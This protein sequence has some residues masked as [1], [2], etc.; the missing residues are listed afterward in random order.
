[1]GVKLQAGEFGIFPARLSK[2]RPYI[3]QAVLAWLWFHKN[4][5]T[6]SCFPSVATLQK[7]CGISS[8]HAVLNA[9][10][11]LEDAG[12]IVKDRRFDDKGNNKSN[13]YHIISNPEGGSAG[14]ALGGSALNAPG[15]VHEMHPNYKKVNN[16]NI[17]NK[18]EASILSE[19]ESAW[20]AYERKGN[21]QT[22]L[23]YWKK[24]SGEDRSS[25][26]KAIPLYIQSRPEKKFR[27]NFEGWINPTNKMWQDEIVVE[28]EVDTK[29]GRMSAQQMK[30]WNKEYGNG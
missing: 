6:N 18:E 12:L 4:N 17:S 28:D 19:F 25:I 24:L 29:K 30:E 21:K 8:K 27:K 1:M 22:S 23:R 5:E 26:M 7:E 3:Q 20:A 13:V 2:G 14:D 15:V 16:K 9:L 10:T 11:A